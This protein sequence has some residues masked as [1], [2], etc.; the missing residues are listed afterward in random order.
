MFDIIRILDYI[1]KILL[2][3]CSIQFVIFLTIEFIGGLYYDFINICP[4]FYNN[5]NNILTNFAF[6]LIY[7]YSKLEIFSRKYLKQINSFM[8]TESKHKKNN[9]Y[10]TE[11][12][13]N[14]EIFGENHMGKSKSKYFFKYQPNNCFQI[15]SYDLDTNGN[16]IQYKILYNNVIHMNDDNTIDKF[17][18]TTFKFI[19]VEFKYGDIV[20]NIKLEGNK[21]NYYVVGNVFT[22]QFFIFYVNYYLNGKIEDDNSTPCIVEILDSNVNKHHIIL[23]NSNAILLKK[24]CHEVISIL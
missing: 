20:F 12:E 7:Y 24:D 2:V 8:K 14:V 10:F 22:K 1:I 23:N 18:N 19:L 13:S 4:E 6:N 16:K 17:E 11:V 15:L 5:I 3:L 21:F 9:E